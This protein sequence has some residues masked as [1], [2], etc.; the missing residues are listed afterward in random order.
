MLN[1]NLDDWGVSL[2]ASWTFAPRGRYYGGTPVCPSVCLCFPLPVCLQ[3][4]SVTAHYRFQVLCMMLNVGSFEKLMELIFQ[5][6]FF[7]DHIWTNGTINGWK[8][9]FTLFVRKNWDFIFLKTVDNERLYYLLFISNF[10][11]GKILFLLF[12]I[13]VNSGCWILINAV[14]QERLK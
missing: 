5:E 6:N 8:E 9:D 2:L 13:L 11:S 10:I 14:S 3:F 1:F 4:F 7:D 12:I